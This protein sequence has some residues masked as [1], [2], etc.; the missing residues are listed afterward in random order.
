MGPGIFLETVELCIDQTTFCEY[1]FDLIYM[2]IDKN[3]VD[4]AVV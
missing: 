1:R 4:C 3:A 2:G